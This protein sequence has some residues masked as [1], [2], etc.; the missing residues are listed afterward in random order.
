MTRKPDTSFRIIGRSIPRTDA[1][2]KVRGKALYLDDLPMPGVWFAE[3]VRAPIACGRLKGLHFNE[4][5]DWS[6]VVVVTP[7][8][9]PGENIVDMTGLDMPFLA[10]D[11]IQYRGEPLALIAAPSKALAREAVSQVR[12]DVE[13]QAS[14]QSIRDIVARHRAGQTDTL[15]LLEKKQ[16][17]K[18]DAARVLGDAAQ[19]IEGEYWTGHQEQLYIEPQSMAAEP[20]ENGGVYI[21]G[22]IQCP[23]YVAPELMKVLNLPL[24][25]IRVEQT[26]TGG[27]FGGK[28]EYPTLPGGY[29]ALLALKAGRPVKMVLDRHDDILYTTKRHPS[30]MHYR[31]ALNDDGSI[32]AMDVEMI[33]DGGAYTTISPV[34]LYRGI[35]HAALGYRCENVTVR[36]YCYASNSFPCGAFRGFGAPQA[37]WGLESHVDDLA[38][39]AGLTPDEFRM[40]NCLQ[41]GDV[42]AT[43]QHLLSSVGTPAVL[44]EA[45]KR[46]NF[47]EKLTRCD[48]GRPGAKKWYGIGLSFFGHGSGFTG[49][50]EAKFG[51][52]AA[53]ELARLNDD[54]PGIILRASSTE[55]GQGAKTVLAQ[56]AAEGISL[57][58]DRVCYPLPDTRVVP[59]SGPTVA[60]RTTMVVGNILFQAGRQ[61]KRHLEEA[62]SLRCFGGEPVRLEYG[63]FRTDSGI[64]RAFNT[65]A[66][67]LLD[68]GDPIR[69]E[70]QFVLPPN[71]QWDQEHFVGDA[72]PAYSWAS[73]VAEVEVDALTLE[74]HLRKITAV[75]DAGR[76]INPTLAL[77]QLQGGLVQTIGYALME[78]MDVRNGL[79]TANRLQTYIIPT[80]LD[81][82]EMDLHFLNDYP[83]DELAPGAKGL[84]EITMNGLAPAIANA[85]YQAT[86]RRLRS[87]P[88]QPEHLHQIMIQG[89]KQP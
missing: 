81:I 58:F 21:R 87:I 55:M 88:M 38:E 74:I 70:Y 32:A 63:V 47:H 30:W 42:T 22:S 1:E 78:S 18:G 20:M 73:N 86:G 41:K 56:M 57:P 60:S 27:A 8:D 59:N 62:A 11:R 89:A 67:V 2:D 75:Y 84:G 3:V 12:A 36:G 82:P 71:I 64:E 79:Y 51:S 33:L 46:S 44:K 61:M 77:G 52:R 14:I 7:Q 65:V 17:V 6:R 35:L 48:H 29:C 13:E 16:I 40:K 39:R 31:T 10:Y 68:G 9:I 76:I 4:A 80:T 83:C 50:G 72:Y 43:G 49:D 54:S 15:R 66:E 37:F 25:K 24:E 53:M 69:A 5:F 23:Y 34:V 26:V 45:L 19:V 28:E 85:V